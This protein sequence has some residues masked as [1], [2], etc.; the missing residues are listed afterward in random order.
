MVH[1]ND[2][3]ASTK[4][5]VRTQRR[6]LAERIR[7]DWSYTSPPSIPKGSDD[8]LDPTNLDQSYA[9]LIDALPDVPNNDY[10]ID[11]SRVLDWRERTI[12]TSDLSSE[13][14]GDELALKS[15]KERVKSAAVA[16]AG[17]ASS[18]KSS[19]A[20]GT[21]SLGSKIKQ[22]GKEKLKS[23]GKR[24][25]LTE[26]TVTLSPEAVAQ[27]AR[28]ESAQA[29]RA[30]ECELR[31]DGRKRK[32]DSSLRGEMA[33]ND[34]LA[35]WTRRRDA[36]S[37]ARVVRQEDGR[38]AEKDE[39][40][41]ADHTMSDAPPPIHISN[42]NVVS[43]L[44]S[45]DK[46]A[47]THDDIALDMAISRLSANRTSTSSTNTASSS[48]LSTSTDL[49]A[50]VTP[51]NIQPSPTHPPQ[52]TTLI[53]L[54]VPLLPSTDPTRAALTPAMYPSIYSKVVVQSLAPSVPI[55]LSH[56]VASLVEGWK[57]DGEWVSPSIG[58]AQRAPPLVPTGLGIRG[59]RRER[60][61]RERENQSGNTTNRAGVIRRR[62]GFGLKKEVS[63]G[64]A[65]ANAVESASCGIGSG[66]L[67][68]LH[69][70][71]TLAQPHQPMPDSLPAFSQTP[72]LQEQQLQ[73]QPLRHQQPIA[74]LA[75]SWSDIATLFTGA[76]P[77]P[78]PPMTSTSFHPHPH[79]HPHQH[80]QLLENQSQSSH[81]APAPPSSTTLTSAAS[82]PAP[83]PPTAS[84]PAFNL[85]SDSPII[86]RST[87]AQTQD[88]RLTPPS[89]AQPQP[90]PQPQ[91]EQQIS[92]ALRPKP[93]ADS[94]QQSVLV[95][96]PGHED[97]DRQDDEEEEERRP[98][99]SALPATVAI[100]AAP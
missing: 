62:H 94:N 32:R 13:E 4:V 43:S 69:D 8:D 75:S 48:H 59:E 16:A 10:T 19:V 65:F 37:C 98:S 67:R 24:L 38:T 68:E 29:D 30:R 52:T 66:R 85:A 25:S 55:N 80:P 42:A 60:R 78:P 53:P 97:E 5:E 35:Y 17:A 56:I 21:G 49:T 23:V 70:A 46:E 72:A 77:P 54:A 40:R 61:H 89:E 22:R 12:A 36:W 11:Q 1:L 6:Q 84:T 96:K 63:T 18:P 14:Q 86:P 93:S 73:Q 47:P 64:G 20:L 92:L 7:V 2:L 41:R 27:A 50:P 90:Q 3:N 71:R 57:K 83:P 99:S 15:V 45:T 81:Q 95:P 34:G 51:S 9:S 87:T 76:P 58:T 74:T 88:H 79:P 100:G 31:R 28:V 82:Q 39:E 91:H 33:W 44:P 26:E